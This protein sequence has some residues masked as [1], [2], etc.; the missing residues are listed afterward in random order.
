MKFD[1]SPVAY[2]GLFWIQENRVLECA[3]CA[4]YQGCSCDL[5]LCKNIICCFLIKIP[6]FSR[7]S[8]IPFQGAKYRE[9]KS[10]LSS[11]RDLEQRA[12]IQ[13]VAAVDVDDANGN[14]N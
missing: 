5:D 10:S 1:Y 14:K 8:G 4:L 13:F 3:H 12:K 6:F 9:K 11:A 7:T 2:T